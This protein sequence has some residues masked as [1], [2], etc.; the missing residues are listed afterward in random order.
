MKIGLPAELLYLEWVAHLK[1]LLD[2][3]F[4]DID[5]RHRPGGS[6]SFRQT[7]SEGDACFPF[8]KMIRTAV[9][10]LPEV[11]LLLV[12]RLVRLDGDLFCPNFRAL[13]DIVVL[14][15]DRLP[16][17]RLSTPVLAPLVEIDSP[18]DY[19]TTLAA[20][21]RELTTA[22][23]T[24][25]PGEQSSQ[26]EKMD[27]L[28]QKAKDDRPAIVLLGRPYIVNDPQ[29]NMGIPGMLEAHGYQVMTAQD[30]EYG[31]LDRLAARL[32]YY[33][34]TL[35]WRESRETLGAFLH[36][37]EQ[38]PPPAGIIFLLSFNC[39]VDALGR[40]ELMSLYKKLAARIPYMVLVVDEHT[41]REHMVTRLE[42]FLDV[43]HGITSH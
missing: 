19:Q 35:Y 2:G 42:A 4:A 5:W 9:G 6:G 32:D 34:K 24:M 3:M 33:A 12:P 40:I 18:S 7:L 8:K 30:L 43:M 1:V 36:F 31:K 14:N 21:V 25:R 17:N 39:G 22:G 28:A 37:T 29:L 13:P 20:M 15:R 11:D 10:L 16:G 27:P 26:T 38:E 41:Q 23:L